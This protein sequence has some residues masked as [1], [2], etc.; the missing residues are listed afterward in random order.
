M[1]HLKCAAFELPFLDGESFGGTDATE[2][3]L[4]YLEQQGFLHH[5][6]G[7]YHWSTEEFPAAEFG[8][9]SVGDENFMIVDITDSKHHQI[10]GEMDRYTVPMLLHEQAIYMHEAQQ[11]QVEKLD[12]ANKKAFIRRVDVGYYT[13]ADLN[14]HLRVLEED[15]AGCAGPSRRARW[16]KCL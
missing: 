2:S 3:M 14:V 7:R 8:L 4:A 13:D 5:S 15:R 9:R 10:I 1:N 16:A 12:F 11:Y 6:G